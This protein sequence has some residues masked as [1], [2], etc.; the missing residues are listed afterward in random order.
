MKDDGKRKKGTGENNRTHRS[1][2][3][4]CLPSI[5]GGGGRNPYC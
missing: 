4:S 2:A 1:A 3:P 5:G